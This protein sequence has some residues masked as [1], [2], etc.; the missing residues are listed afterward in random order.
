LTVNGRTYRRPVVVEMDPR[1]KIVRADLEQYLELERKIAAQLS[2]SYDFYH[3]AAGLRAAA[4][5]N[6]QALANDA[7]GGS[8][9][10]ALKAFDQKTLRLE[11]EPRAGGGGGPGKPK[12][13]FAVINGLFGGLAAM[14]D[15][16]DMAPTAAMRS[17]YRD[18]CNDLGK[19]RAQWSTLL[20]QDLP[21]LNAA[22]AQRGRPALSAPAP[23]AEGPACEEN[24]RPVVRAPGK[25]HP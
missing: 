9:L 21:A 22:L 20:S 23:P 5:K 13:S 10:E 14:V 2:V 11:G 6:A 17:A 12:P 4:D 19:I 3:Q 7:Q 1:V 24:P 18:Y 8:V 15:G 16:A 25:R